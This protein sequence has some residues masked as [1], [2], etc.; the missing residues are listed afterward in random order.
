MLLLDDV[1]YYCKMLLLDDV[2]YDDE[3]L[4]ITQYSRL[5]VK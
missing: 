4:M 5:G 1:A 2:T 3:L